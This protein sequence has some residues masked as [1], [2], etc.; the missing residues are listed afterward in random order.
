MKCRKDFFQQADGRFHFA[1]VH[2]RA[3]AAD[4]FVDGGIQQRPKRLGPR[5]EKNALGAAVVAISV[6]KP[7]KK[8]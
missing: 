6:I 5:G 2:A 4:C 8:R 1:F 7:W 3:G